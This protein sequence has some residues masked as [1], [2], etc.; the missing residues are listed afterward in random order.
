[1]FHLFNKIYLEH[2]SHYHT[3]TN[4]M[5]LVNE[6]TSHPM[7]KN[8][9]LEFNHTPAFEDFLKLNYGGDIET[10]WISLLDVK[11]EFIIF[12]DSVIFHKLQMQLWKS[13]FPKCTSEKLFELYIFFLNDYFLKKFLFSNERNPLSNRM[14]GPYSFDDFS[15]FNSIYETI[16]KSETLVSIDKAILS[17]EYLMADYAYNSSSKY[18]DDFINRVEKL[19]WK[20]WFN[21][22]NSV[23][24]DIIGCFYDV[25]KLVPDINI[26]NKNIKEIFEIIASDKKLCWI[27]D[28]KFNEKNISYI[29]K[30][31]PPNI[32]CNL[33]KNINSIW[34]YSFNQFKQVDEPIAFDQILFTNLL[35]EGKYLEILERD[36][37]KGFGCFFVNDK[38]KDKANLLYSSFLYEKMRK[39]ETNELQFYQLG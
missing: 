28:E 21:D 11:E 18:S 13:I 7:S 27:T 8:F 5:I 36:I 34:G 25:H 9:N 12:A 37:L 39:K 29:K 17:F 2:D 14:K 15:S 10:F 26:Q 16:E 23:K 4:H 6:S 19:A 3:K 33:T 31:Y 22:M 30:N 35:Y 38:I 24:A 1:M 20:S 32:I